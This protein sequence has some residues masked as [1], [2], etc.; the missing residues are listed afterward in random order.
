[1]NTTDLIAALNADI[2]TMDALIK[3]HQQ[4]LAR[5]KALSKAVANNPRPNTVDE[6]LSLHGYMVRLEDLMS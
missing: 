4:T 5:L 3:S 2:D 6:A 1:M